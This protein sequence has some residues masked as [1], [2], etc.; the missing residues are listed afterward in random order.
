MQIGQSI[1]HNGVNVTL[2]NRKMRESQYENITAET[3][4]GDIILIRRPNGT[5][6]IGVVTSGA[7]G[8]VSDAKWFNAHGSE[9]SSG[10]LPTITSVG[11]NSNNSLYVFRVTKA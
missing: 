10:R 6:H 5:G 4:Q 3:K 11:P 7:M 2:I 1:V 9:T 8:N